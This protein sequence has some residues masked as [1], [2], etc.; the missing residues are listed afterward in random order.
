MGGVEMHTI[1]VPLAPADEAPF[2]HGGALNAEEQS[3][4]STKRQKRRTRVA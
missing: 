2:G 1:R 3:D 4:A